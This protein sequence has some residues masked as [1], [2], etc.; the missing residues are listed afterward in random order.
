MHRDFRSDGVHLFFDSQSINSYV[1]PLYLYVVSTIYE[2]M[3]TA[4]GKRFDCA[5]LEAT[6]GSLR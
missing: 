3:N 6:Q 4:L 1:K 2:E 5:Q